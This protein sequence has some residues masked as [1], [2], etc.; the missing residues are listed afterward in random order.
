MKIAIIDIYN[1]DIGL[2]ILFPDSDYYIFRI[3]SDRSESLKKFN[4]N[5]RYDIENINDKNYDTIFIIASL[6]DSKI[7][8][9]FFKQYTYDS[10]EKIKQ[11]ITQNN[12]KN[13]C[14]FDNYDYDYDPNDIINNNKITFFKRNYNKNKYYKDNVHSFPFI[15]FGEKSIVEKVLQ[16]KETNKNS[17]N[18]IF[19][20]GTLFEHNDVQNNWYKNRI[21]LYNDISNYIY[22]PG[23]VDYNTFLDEIHNSKFCLDLNG[24]GDPNKRTFEI[25][26]QGS[27]RIGEFNTLK[28]NFKEEFSEE[29]IFKNK[30]EFVEKIVLLLNNEELYKKCLENQNNIFKK[31]FNIEYLRNY[32][33]SR[34]K[35][36]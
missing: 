1:Q 10:I 17:I 14:F 23:K 26:S 2:K 30:E 18:R 25:L 36:F 35:N 33:L 31:Y 21:R 6:Y 19:F 27:L 15:M 20:S 5:I 12:F 8:T 24:V 29:T 11:I 22:N 32:I 13:I 16:N 4:I 34:I 28:W 7:Q 9:N 3:E